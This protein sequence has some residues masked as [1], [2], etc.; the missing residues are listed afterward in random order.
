MIINKEYKIESDG[1][2]ITVLRFR[3]SNEKPDGT[4]SKESCNPEAYFGKLESALNYLVDK[5]VKETELKDLKTVLKAIE[6]TKSEIL[7]A[8]KGKK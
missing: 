4:M 1:L 7:K 6:E 5:K 8:L 2:N 3:P